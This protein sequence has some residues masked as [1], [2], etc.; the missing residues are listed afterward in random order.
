MACFTGL[1]GTWTAKQDSPSSSL[2]LPFG[3]SVSGFDATC[4]VAL[5][6]MV[7]SAVRQS[8][9]R[10]AL[11]RT[12]C[13]A[14]RVISMTPRF[15]GHLGTLVQRTPR[16]LRPQCHR[17]ASVRRA[18]SRE[19]SGSLEFEV[20]LV[21]FS[22]SASEP[23]V[24]SEPPTLPIQRRAVTCSAKLLASVKLSNC[25]PPDEEEQHD[26]PSC[27]DP[28]RVSSRK[29]IGSP[30]SPLSTNLTKQFSSIPSL[31]ELGEMFD[32]LVQKWG[33]ADVRFMREVVLELNGTCN[34]QF[35]SGDGDRL[36]SM[37]TQNGA[38]DIDRRRFQEGV[39]A[40]LCAAQAAKSQDLSLTQLRL[41]LATAFERFDM[42]GN[43]EISS[44]EFLA[45]LQRCDIRLPEP[46]ALVLL[47]FFGKETVVKE[48]LAP[49][50]GEQ[51]E[52]ALTGAQE[53]MA[54]TTGWSGVV[55]M[56]EWVASWGSD[57]PV[58]QAKLLAFFRDRTEIVADTTEFAATLGAT[59]LVLNH[60][61]DNPPQL[62]TGEWIQQLQL[63]ANEFTSA[64][65]SLLQSTPAGSTL[66]SALLAALNAVC[67]KSEVVPLN[68]NEALLYARAF[69]QK[70]FSMRLFRKLLER[71]GYRWVKASKGDMI[72]RAEDGDIKILVQGTASRVGDDL[73]QESIKGGQIILE[74]SIDVIACE[75]VVFIVWDK[76]HLCDRIAGADD[77]MLTAMVSEIFHIDEGVPPTTPLQAALKLQA[78]RKGFTSIGSLS[79]GFKQIICKEGISFDEKLEQCK[80]L[81]M[82]SSSDLVESYE[83][84][85][86][87]AGACSA[88]LALSNQSSA[89][90][91]SPDELLQLSPLLILL[92]IV[93][94]QVMRRNHAS[95]ASSP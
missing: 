74:E 55:E 87:L 39:H 28:E 1:A 58:S 11:G 56:V 42:D 49:S 30:L 81:L 64:I 75:D 67:T 3:A 70:G 23:R 88:L 2:S 79:E 59:V 34:V 37:L 7:L 13:T 62:D 60:L 4:A 43:G 48:N 29:Q 6:L 68:E 54:H 63:V 66:A 40:L 90:L 85:V 36:H 14:R 20:A 83:A 16:M 32:H 78:K 12:F 18:W 21:P 84:L 22:R 80:T 61:H 45:A 86:D 10:R 44:D 41:V 25:P 95:F 50:L 72:H 76:A 33:M 35:Q 5:V 15:L 57:S 65:N 51:C 77:P 8:R 46:E 93:L 27:T 31:V 24:E 91:A 71:G 19:S 47:R 9:A 73:P 52:A 38:V 89:S 69:H 94:G 53:R 26:L 92:G 17:A 82:D